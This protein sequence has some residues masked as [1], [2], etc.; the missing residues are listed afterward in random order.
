[1]DP[2]ARD[3]AGSGT[4]QWA[5][6]NYNIGRG[7]SN[8]CAYCYARADAVDRWKRIPA[9]EWT[10]ERISQAAVDKKWGTRNG[11]I[12]FPSTHDVTPFYLE[13]AV[14][15]LHNILKAGNNVLIVSKPHLKCIERLC[16]ELTDYHRQILFRFTIG[17]MY[18]LVTD[19]W[20]PGAPPPEERLE[21]LKLAKYIGYNTSVSIEPNLG[22]VQN[23][24]EVVEAVENYV[25]HDIWIGHMNKIDQRVKED[26]PELAEAI[27][28]LRVAQSDANTMILYT[29]LKNHP[30][31]A[32]KE[33]I[34]AVVARCGGVMP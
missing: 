33:S 21:A 34:Q 6:H 12:M 13:A 20:E 10:A 18:R 30:K 17:S 2:F 16:A 14:T 26:N 1:M 15:T 9:A 28:R 24:V 8:N 23:A 3:R 32:W 29:L 19:L 25:T 7:C 27:A 31:V 11:V 4:K 5:E 22:G